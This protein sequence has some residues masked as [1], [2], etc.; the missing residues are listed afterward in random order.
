MKTRLISPVLAAS[1]IMASQCVFAADGTITFAGDFTAQT[2]TINGNGSGSSNFTV[3]LPTVSAS[4]LTTA[5]ATA[6]RTP[7][8]IALTH[9]T[10]ASGTVHTFFQPGQIDMTTGNLVLATGGAS[11]VE[12]QLQNADFSN[13]ALNKADS[14][15]NSKSA[16]I[17]NGAA[18]LNYYA[19]YVATGRATPGSAN[20]SVLYT[21]SYQ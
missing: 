1:L 21:I 3:A 18:T 9:C 12:I 5:G 16:V 2:C 4:S 13:I 14:A 19:Q 6:G 7:F 10:Q 11:N 20:S 15:Q 8:R 17:G